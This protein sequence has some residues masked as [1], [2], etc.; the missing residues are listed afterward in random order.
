MKNYT[1]NK[2]LNEYIKELIGQGWTVEYG[3]HLKLRSPEGRL[4][5]CSY[6]PSCPHVATKVRADVKRLQRRIAEEREQHVQAS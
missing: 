3:K 4:V 1:T 5:S 2:N 6:S